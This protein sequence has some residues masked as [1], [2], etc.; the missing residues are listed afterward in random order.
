[1]VVGAGQDLAPGVSHQTRR[2]SSYAAR[3][4]SGNEMMKKTTAIAVPTRPLE[5]KAVSSA[6]LARLEEP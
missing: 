1:M 3:R 6:S 2:R 5:A 4:V